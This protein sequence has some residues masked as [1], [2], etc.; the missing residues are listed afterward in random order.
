MLDLIPI[1][2]RLLAMAGVLL[3]TFLAGGV[4]GS[5][6]A[7]AGFS[8]ERQT[9]ATDKATQAGEI[10]DLKLAISEQNGK[11]ELLKAGTKAAEQ[12]RDKAQEYADTLAKFSKSRMDKLQAALAQTCG[13][14][15]RNYW[16]L[17]K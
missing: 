2:F 3:A 12:A 17:R 9:C 11:V 14:V 6:R 15:T 16:D 7:E 13:D 1:Q 5:W 8:D 4:V 10:S